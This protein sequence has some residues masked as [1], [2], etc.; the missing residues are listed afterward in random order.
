MQSLKTL[1]NIFARSVKRGAFS[2]LITA[3]ILGLLGSVPAQALDTRTIDIVSIS[4]NRSAPLA[5]TLADA[6][7]EIESKVGPLWRQLTT[8]SGDPED[9]RI[10]FTFG[11]AL[12][13]PIKINFAMPCENNFNTWTSAVRVETY[14]RL[15]ITDYQARYL[16]ILA[17]DAGC[18]WTGR[19]LIGNV[20]KPGGALVLHNSIDGFVVA[21]EL[22]HALGLGHSNL[23]RCT[24]GAADSNWNNCRA[25]EYGGTID[26]MGNVDV[27]T[28][29][30]TYHQWR[31]GLLKESD[32][33]QSWKS[34]TIEINA[35]D[36]FG[37]P[38]AIFM[39]DG[40]STYWIEYRTASPRY[41][42]GLVIY[43]TDP[44]PSSSIQSPNA[45]DAQ[46][47][48]TEAVGTDIWMLNLD[49]YSYAS[50]ASSGSM[51]LEP[52]KSATVFSGNI[53]ISVSALSENSAAV[54]ISRRDSGDLKKPILNPISTWRSP[55][56]PILSSSY[57]ESVSDIAD[58]EARI[59][60]DTKALTSSKIA[61]WQPTYLNPFTPPQVLQLKDLPEGQYSLAIRV[62]NLSGVWSPW[63]DPIQ[64]NID[65]ALPN[66]GS[67]YAVTKVQAGRIFVELSE[68]S[69]A[70]SGLCAT[71]VINSEGW[72]TAKSSAKS[73]PQ[74]GLK[75]GERTVGTLQVFDCLGNGR[76]AKFSAE[77]NFA[78]A[79][80]MK[81]NGNWLN[82]TNEFP[83]GAMKCVGRCTAYLATN[84]V[85]GV[86]LGAGIA[87]VSLTGKR[88][89]A[90]RA[91]KS[92][93]SY[94]AI[95]LFVGQRN[96]SVRVSGSNFTLL[97]IA[98]ATAQ[99]SEVTTAQS[100]ATEPDRSL[101]EPIQKTLNRYGFN[102]S[103]F[104][105][106]WNVFPMGRGTTLEDPT[107]DLCSAK[108]DSEL[109]RK[110]RR[111]VVA[112]KP[113]N[114]Y[115][116]LS[117]EVVRYRSIA[118]ATQAL[119]E[120]KESYANCIKNGGGTERDGVFTKYEFLELPKI[121]DSLVASSQRVIVH[122]K[123]GENESTRYLFG[124]Y[125]YTGDLF[126]GLY[127]VSPSTR[128]FSQEEIVRWLDVA[129]V[130]AERL[131]N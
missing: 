61:N 130:M 117:T 106:E 28:P 7:R 22:G 52:G 6:Q 18:I 58:F 86:V 116:F 69:D 77:S 29:L 16:L 121:P 110:E 102:S 15:G 79:S 70:G 97:G 64:A 25:V 63:S 13:E 9:K 96:K 75:T 111:Q 87:E 118:S 39:R 89:K 23:M 104:S 31:M 84:G 40:K 50:S 76:A 112:T 71:Q 60:G 1:Q 27:S 42:A 36:V 12:P 94:G 85:A 4:W 131:K 48:V 120:V 57:T 32:I 105:S 46:Q 53:S 108:Y 59:D 88:P 91:S 20:D 93:D 24:N 17:P 73:K 81:R 43:R 37:K 67:D 78:T 80:A 100:F 49:N 47:D 34:E 41:K 109:S 124:A 68:V 11:K 74:I 72:I 92:A 98:S 35:V 114:P 125:Q 103:D 5:G 119:N 56:A 8:I 99:I 65:R 82:A 45:Y 44:P 115:L 19:A 3:L 107:L 66:V 101:E 54:K 123:I 126:T 38:R 14:K 33:R 127:V 2:S 122:A 10:E 55:D 95:S 129:R 90:I 30:S 128:P 26:L 113:G 51:S 62:R 21:H 83:A